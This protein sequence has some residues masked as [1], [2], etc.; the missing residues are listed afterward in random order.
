MRRLTIEASL[1]EVSKFLN[2]ESL[3]GKLELFE[4]ISILREES[5]EWSIV[6]RVKMKNS[7]STFNDFFANESASIQ[8]L[9]SEKDGSKVYFLKTNPNSLASNVLATGSYFSLPLEIKE[10]RLKASFLGTPL[11]IR[12]LLQLIGK[13]GIQYRIVAVSDASFSPTSPLGLLTEKQQKVLITAYQMGYYDIPKKT[14]TDQIAKKLHIKGPTVV[15]HRE[16]AE[17]RIM[18]SLLS[19]C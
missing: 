15:R 9:E 17:K 10:R 19:G 12:R 6:C 2:V 13:S 1:E 16:K 5:S 18:S 11:Q 14:S 7:I 4:V 8:L 3:I